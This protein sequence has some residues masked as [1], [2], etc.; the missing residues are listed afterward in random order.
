MHCVVVS[1]VAAFGLALWAPPSAAQIFDHLACSKVKDP[2]PRTVYDAEVLSGDPMLA[3][4]PG[5]KVKV[6]AKL[7]C[8][9]AQKTNVVPPPPGAPEGPAATQYL[10]YTL[11]C[12]RT[13]LPFTVTDQFGSR[14][15]EVGNAKLLCAPVASGSVTTTTTSTTTTSTTG[16]SCNGNPVCAAGTMNLGTRSGDTGSESVSQMGTGEAWLRVTLTEDSATLIDVTGHISLAS[17][18]GTNYDL[19]VYCD[20]CG[21]PNFASSALPGPGAHTDTVNALGVDEFP[22]GGSDDQLDL[23][24]EV[25]YAS[26]SACGTWTLTVQGNT[27]TTPDLTC[28]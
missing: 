9:D 10:C 25:R 7:L 6:P 13:R 20:A 1:V 11:K 18:S 26:G 22:F 27:P 21:G 17:P 15:L 4:G 12:P 3:F 28:N 23:V 16:T 24:I 2:S 8:V 14:T 19:F 5:C